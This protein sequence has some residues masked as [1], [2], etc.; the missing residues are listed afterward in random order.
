MNRRNQRKA[1]AY[2]DTIGKCC[3][4]ECPTPYQKRECHHIKPIAKGGTDDIINYVVLCSYCHRR[5][6]RHRDW[7][8]IE[9]QLLMWKF[10]AE[11]LIIGYTADDYTEE[12]YRALLK[13]H[14]K[15]RA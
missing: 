15:S 6:K 12:E 10:M 1:E 8:D 9:E 14:D 11:I 2:R 7:R 13:A 4:P 3:N 5:G